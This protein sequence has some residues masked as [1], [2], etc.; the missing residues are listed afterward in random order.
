MKMDNY[1]SLL[2]RKRL[3]LVIMALLIAAA[4]LF[5]AASGSAELSL[6]EIILSLLGQG[7]KNSQIILFNI[8]LPRIAAAIVGGAGLAAAGCVMQ[9]LLH[10]P[11]AGASTLGVSQGAAFG[12]AFAIIVLGAGSA[13]SSTSDGISFSNPLGISVCAFIGSML[14]T[15][16]ILGLSRFK[17]ISPQVMVLTGVA[18]S[19]LFQGATS[20]MQYF[21][22]EVK[23]SAVV[24]WTYGSL[25][26]V[27]WR[28]IGIMALAVAAACI[29]FGF[30]RKNFNALLLGEQTARSLGTNSDRLLLIGMTVCSAV[31]SI[32]VSYVGII[33]FIG[34]SAPH[35]MRR[36]FGN[37]SRFLLPASAMAGACLLLLSDTAARLIVKPVILPI[38]A[39]TSFLGAP[40]FLWL[41]FKGVK[42]N[43]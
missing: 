30:N 9:T 13:G 8:R 22:D 33:N 23:V 1:K 37:D 15:A 17:K 27:T 16:V 38:G 25:G 36:F 26:S 3:Y 39:I 10:N 2:R 12:A 31:T 41:I 7:D 18:L 32:I 4:A 5:S 40:L 20:L 11:L 43:A 42:K 21:A 19:S 34:L 6:P 35:L 24:F 14:S 29:Y 28:E